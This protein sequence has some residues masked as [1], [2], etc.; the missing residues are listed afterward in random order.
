MSG[1]TPRRRRP[2]G[3]QNPRSQGLTCDVARVTRGLVWSRDGHSRARDE[4]SLDTSHIRGSP[5]APAYIICLNCPSSTNSICCWAS[6]LMPPRRPTNSAGAD[7]EHTLPVKAARS[8]PCAA[9]GRRRW[10]WR[11]HSGA[12]R[13]FAGDRGNGPLM[14]HR[15]R[16]ARLGVT[17]PMPLLV[18]LV[19]AACRSTTERVKSGHRAWM[20]PGYHHDRRAA[21]DCLRWQDAARRARRRPGNLVHLLS[22]SCQATCTVPAQLAVKGKTNEPPRFGHF[23]RRSTSP[24][25]SSPPH[26]LHC[27]RETAEAIVEAWRRLHPDRQRPTSPSRYAETGS[28]SV[29]IHPCPDRSTNKHANGRT[30]KRSA[31]SD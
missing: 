7:G 29:E 17:G 4:R 2:P 22:G 18:R 24:T 10:R 14:P 5:A 1:E 8:T 12:W 26:A 23:S 30:T 19:A 15:R 6:W 25:R 21:G 20:R 3:R 31:Q 28:P 27:Q 16:L 9:R 13:S 11:L